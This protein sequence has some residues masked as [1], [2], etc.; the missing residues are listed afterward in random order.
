MTSLAISRSEADQLLAEEE[1][2]AALD[3][4]DVLDTP[5]EDGFDAIVRLV[6]NIFDVPVGI[7]SVIDAHR[8]WYKAA[9]GLSNTEIA[10]ADSLCD[11]TI[12]QSQ[13]LVVSDASQDDRFAA[14]PNVAGEPHVRFYAGVPLRTLDG[15]AIGT[16]C[17]IDFKPRTC[18]REQVE[19]LADLARVAMA[20][21]EMRPLVRVDRLTGLFSTRAFG[22]EAARSLALA[23][24]H[25]LDIS[26]IALEIDGLD[27]VSEWR[28]T[29]GADAVLAV[30]ARR[31]EALLR[32]TDLV[33][34]AAG[35]RLVVLLP[36]TDLAG[37]REVAEKLRA[38][39][40]GTPIEVAGAPV[41]FTL[42][43]G[44][45][46]MDP[47]ME[48]IETLLFRAEEA[49]LR[50]RHMGGDRCVAWARTEGATRAARRRVLKSGVITFN[51][52]RS[53]IDCTVRSLADDGAALDLFRASGLPQ[54]FELSIGAEERTRE[55]R[56]VSRT[57][58]HAEVEFV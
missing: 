28:G 47:D 48:D 53:R 10:R 29:A 55:C 40:S 7:V 52:G 4:L 38:M 21:F 19:M 5:R 12:R 37:S 15:H 58:R 56:L 51:G 27:D 18:T 43:F 13:V 26:C 14:N 16:L 49:L 41:R 34:R 36:H 32:K 24:R 17:A 57:E 45:A 6:R 9:E 23:R 8:Q 44:A 20:E 2:L 3:R 33:G 31:C 1:R 54:Q 42:S 35:S 50:A 46:M 25:E 30:V 11:V 39:I 22:E